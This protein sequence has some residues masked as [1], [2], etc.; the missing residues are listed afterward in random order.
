MKVGFRDILRVIL[1]YSS[2]FRLRGV[3]GDLSQSPSP[4]EGLCI[5]KAKTC[6]QGGVGSLQGGAPLLY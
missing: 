1:L 6:A 5:P 4:F 3:C 2:G